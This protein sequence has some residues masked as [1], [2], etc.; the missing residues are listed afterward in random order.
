M[1]DELDEKMPGI[2]GKDLHFIKQSHVIKEI[3]KAGDSVIVGRSC[4]HVLMTA[5]FHVSVY[6]SVHHMRTVSAEKCCLTIRIVGKQKSLSVRQI[7]AER[8]LMIIIPVRNGV[9]RA[10]FD[11]CINSACYGID[12]TVDLLERLVQY[13]LDKK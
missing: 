2:G 6:L 4:G 3:A 9:I 8:H 7:S 12:G 5:V 13:S 11:I 1:I 10:D